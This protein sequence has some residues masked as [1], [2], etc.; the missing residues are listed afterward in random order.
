MKI[1]FWQQT[2]LRQQVPA[3]GPGGGG[4]LTYKNDGGALRALYKSKTL[5]WYLLGC[6]V[7]KGP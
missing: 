3:S 4:G 7:S 1:Q 2:I 5:F 6:L